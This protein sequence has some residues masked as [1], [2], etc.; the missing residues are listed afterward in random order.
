MTEDGTVVVVGDIGEEFGADGL[1]FRTARGFAEKRHKTELK[2]QL[3]ALPTSASVKQKAEL[4]AALSKPETLSEASLTLPASGS[5]YQLFDFYGNPVPA[6]RGKITVPLDGRGYF[7]RG[8]GK[9]GSFAQL[10]SALQKSAISGIEP[11]AVVAH[12]MTSRIENRPSMTLTID[13]RSEPPDKRKTLRHAWQPAN[14]RPE[15]VAI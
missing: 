9:P 5:R 11:L 3:A 6:K 8:N 15:N 7:L 14:N 12:D 2:A 13:E 4:T 10:I 1:P